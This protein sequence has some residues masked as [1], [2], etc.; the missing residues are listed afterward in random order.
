MKL[1]PAGIEINT[2]AADAH[3]QLG[4]RRQRTL[5]APEDDMWAAFA[6]VAHPTR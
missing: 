1:D 4:A 6:D 2:H 5:V 3:R